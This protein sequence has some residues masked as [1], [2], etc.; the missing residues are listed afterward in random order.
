MK[1]L[2]YIQSNEQKINPISREIK[3]LIN[4]KDFLDKILL[5]GYK[6]ANNIA[7]KKIKKMREIVGF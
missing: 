1:I 6:K 2:T 7:S 5:E 3:R 4:D